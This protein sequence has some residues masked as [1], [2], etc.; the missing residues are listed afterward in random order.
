LAREERQTNCLLQI[1]KEYL[2]IPN[3]KGVRKKIIVC[4]A[5]VIIK[6][7]MFINA[8]RFKNKK[9]RKKIE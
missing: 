9:E 4:I 5:C 1:E 6:I 7:N 8:C 3:T 2:T